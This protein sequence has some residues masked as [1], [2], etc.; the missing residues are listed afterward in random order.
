MARPSPGM[1][2]ERP[3]IGALG[4][5]RLGPEEVPADDPLTSVTPTVEK[6]SY[7]STTAAA[8]PPQATPQRMRHPPRRPPGA[9]H[10]H[11]DCDLPRRIRPAELD[12]QLDGSAD[13]PNHS[14]TVA[15]WHD[16]KHLDRPTAEL[17]R[18]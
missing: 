3:V 11:R 16:W 12:F 15:D 2:I 9:D 10:H 5:V 7:D 8:A 1:G 4:D 17:G 13:T 18:N 14:A 6:K